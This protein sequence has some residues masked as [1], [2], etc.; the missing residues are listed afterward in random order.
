MA[1]QHNTIRQYNPIYEL[2][3]P[4][5]H[6][7]KGL[8]AYDVYKQEKIGE[9]KKYKQANNWKE[10]TNAFFNN[11]HNTAKQNVPRYKKEGEKIYDLM[12]KAMIADYFQNNSGLLAQTTDDDTEENKKNGKN[13]DFWQKV[14]SSVV[15]RI[16]W[17][18]LPMIIVLLSFVVAP[19]WSM[20]MVKL[21]RPGVYEEVIKS[22]SNTQSISFLDVSN[23]I[24]NS[25][26]F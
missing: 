1:K 10:P 22:Q 4:E 7:L 25:Q 13:N 24:G 11:F 15:A 19:Q 12:Q 9:I 26:G 20:K 17:T 18:V 16:I 2:L 5:S 21:I 6:D 3:V 14:W 23:R 8:C